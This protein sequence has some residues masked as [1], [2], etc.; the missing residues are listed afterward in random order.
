M[1]IR[2]DVDHTSITAA[3]GKWFNV[4]ATLHKHKIIFFFVCFQLKLIL[5]T[6]NHSIWRGHTYFFLSTFKHLWNLDVSTPVDCMNFSGELYLKKKQLDIF[7]FDILSSFFFSN[8]QYTFFINL[9]RQMFYGWKKKI[10]RKCTFNGSMS[11]PTF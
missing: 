1:N 2:R 10:W 6:E 5:E 4:I 11:D 3:F 7:H 9:R 8:C